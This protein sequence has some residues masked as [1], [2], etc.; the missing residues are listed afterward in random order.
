VDLIFFKKLQKKKTQKKKTQ[1]NNINPPSSAVNLIAFLISAA[2]HEVIV[3]VPFRNIKM[4]AFLGMII[5]VPM[6]LLTRRLFPNKGSDWGN[7][8]FWCSILLGQPL[9][10]L[11][12][13]YQYSVEMA[14]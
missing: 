7:A 2:L 6:V 14:G 13:F 4:W 8:I 3:S 9:L 1:K 11:T 12:Y 5:Q 10:V